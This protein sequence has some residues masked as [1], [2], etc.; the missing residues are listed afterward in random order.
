MRSAIRV[1]IIW[2]WR[3]EIGM[4]TGDSAVAKAT[5]ELANSIRSVPSVDAVFRYDREKQQ[6]LLFARPWEK[7]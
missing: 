6:E 3:D 1:R 7:E 5:F 4:A 2:S